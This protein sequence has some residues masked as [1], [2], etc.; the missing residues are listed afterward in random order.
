VDV[1][2]KI[3]ALLDGER[4]TI[5]VAHLLREKVIPWAFV[6]DR[7][8]DDKMRRLR[9]QAVEQ[10][11]CLAA[12]P[13]QGP[14]LRTLRCGEHADCLLNDARQAE[15]R[16]QGLP[17]YDERTVACPLH[18]WGFR[19][20]LEVPPQQQEDEGGET[21]SER[22]TITPAGPLQLAAGLNATLALCATHWTELTQALVWNAPAYERDRILDLLRTNE[23]D[24][25]YFYCH[26]R[27]G[28]VDP[29]RTNPPYLEFQAAG[30]APEQIRPQDFA[31][32]PAWSHGPLVFL[33]AC[34]TLGYSPDALSPFLKTLVDGRK[35][36][37]VL[38]TEVPVAEALARDLSRE[39]LVRFVA[40]ATAGQALLDARR[41]LL[42]GNN[43]LG[44]VYT[45]FAPADLVI[46]RGGQP[47]A[48]PPA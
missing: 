29:N 38:G 39:F 3:T 4:K 7:P 14:G 22:R 33:N 48:A 17:C 2:Q 19:H 11:V 12:V 45:L 23:P 1:Q 26:A 46:E 43:P 24:V 34:G 20:A 6:Y 41:I 18:F 10:G 37:G 42:T 40:G 27:G 8:Y 35:A 13:P 47:P 21:R 15:R 31:G 9:G 5:H 25:I 28:Q 44:L 36:S 16:A 32:D 30:G